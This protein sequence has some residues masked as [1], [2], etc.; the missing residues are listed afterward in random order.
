[1]A[2]EHFYKNA[3]SDLCESQFADHFFINDNEKAD[4]HL[5]QTSWSF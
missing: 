3:L 4:T 1:M 2:K 5:E